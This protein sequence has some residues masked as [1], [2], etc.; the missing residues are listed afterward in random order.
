MK[1]ISKSLYFVISPQI[2]YQPVFKVNFERRNFAILILRNL[3]VPD[4]TN[5]TI[6]GIQE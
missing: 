4:I 3:R 1:R 6:K 2:F 5:Q